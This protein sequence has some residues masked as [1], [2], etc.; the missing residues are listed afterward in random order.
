MR[1]R[2]RHAPVN[3]PGRGRKVLGLGSIAVLA[4]VLTVP[5]GVQASP[6]SSAAGASVSAGADHA[7]YNYAA[8]ELRA[9]VWLD[10]SGDEVYRRGDHQ[11]VH[12]QTNGDAY[13]VVYRID[14][15]GRVE[16][17]WPRSRL[18]DGFVFGYH[19]YT[20]PVGGARQLRVSDAEGVGYIQIV[21]SRYP[22]DLRE[23]QLD[24]FHEPLE[25]PY[26]FY[27]A[28]DPFLAMNEVNFV[29]TGLED[30]ADFVIT[31]YASYYVHR[32]VD[33]PRY[34]CSQCHIGEEAVAVSDPYATNCVVDIRHDY[35]W[36]NEWYVT[37]GYYPVYHHP[38]YYYVDPWTYRPWINYWYRPWYAWPTVPV[39]SWHFTP[40][41][42]WDS[43]YWHGDVYAHYG[44][45]K[46]SG[47]RY[48][49]LDKDWLRRGL[50]NDDRSRMPLVTQ[51]PD[52]R[53]V[54][55][56]RDRT[57]LA[58]A[59]GRIAAGGADA[60]ERFADRPELKR[61]RKDFR[62]D[63]GDDRAGLRIVDRKARDG[64][65]RH[66]GASE[67]LRGSEVRL[68]TLDA[69][70]SGQRLID[71]EGRAVRGRDD[72]T[73]GARGGD[74]DARLR[75]RDVRGRDTGL[76]SRPRPDRP[77]TRE[78]LRA[79]PQEDRGRVIRP[80]EPRNR[81]T[82]VWS[83]RSGSRTG[84]DRPDSPAQVRPAPRGNDTRRDTPAVRPAPRG[85]D[86]R[87]DAPAARPAPRGGTRPETKVDRPSRPATRSGGERS[88]VE[89]PRSS[90]GNSGRSATPQSRSSGTSS[91]GRS[92]GG[93]LP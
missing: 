36:T 50:G 44:R 2:A 19:E 53:I 89:S 4:A 17:L 86:T 39:Y 46:S 92:R 14:A 55:A 51:R 90:G 26:D 42:W 34:L 72:R 79:G 47:T 3:G 9:E 83:G 16:V 63:R 22:Y 70:D 71:L 68:R 45:Y 84:G 57:R 73:T 18:D 43:P 13:A 65:F 67:P 25:R 11:R 15:E 88:R 80:V 91:G 5:A 61:D 82:R 54:K 10:R 27:V 66:G 64:G 31:N 48:R 7:D 12:F 56:M 58:D 23:L 75:S 62:P 41:G 24:F 21:A 38:V 20:L 76:T 78:A 33:Y 85:N 28:G 60:R 77:T 52:D 93:R 1:N 6:T 8:Q 69:R 30:A 59:R 40:W 35:G 37:F 87:R 29:V 49:P 74:D 32:V 81:G